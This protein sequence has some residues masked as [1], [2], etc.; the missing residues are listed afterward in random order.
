MFTVCT[1]NQRDKDGAGKENGGKT[2]QRLAS[3]LDFILMADFKTEK[4]TNVRS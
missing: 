1:V 4:F 3:V 2:I